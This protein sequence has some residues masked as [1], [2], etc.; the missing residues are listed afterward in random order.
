[1]TVG[2]RRA[3]GVGVFWAVLVAGLATSPAAWAQADPGS[4]PTARPGPGGVALVDLGASADRP[5]VQ[6]GALPVL[7]MGTPAGWTAVVGLALNAKPGPAVLQLQRA[8]AATAKLS[9][10][11]QPQRYAEQRLTV[12]PGQ[13]DLS[14]ADLAR[15]QREREHQRHLAVIASPGAD[16]LGG[17]APGQLRP[18]WRR[19]APRPE[20]PRKN[21]QPSPAA[22]APPP[23]QPVYDDDLHSAPTMIIDIGRMK[24]GN[25]R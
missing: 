8:G 20:P 25:Q 24:R 13:V 19:H 15:Y 11:I 9:F 12:K 17:Q 3:S 22:A 5:L 16:A 14:A 6:L 10:E 2:V 23:E 21:R 1:M 4:L 7:V 18:T